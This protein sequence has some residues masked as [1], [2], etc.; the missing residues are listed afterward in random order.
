MD[1]EKKYGKI[2]LFTSS[3]CEECEKFKPEWIK[4]LKEFN[5]HYQHLF[6][7]NFIQHTIYNPL[8]KDAVKQREKILQY[9]EKGKD[10]Y[11][12][13]LFYLGGADASSTS[14]Y[15]PEKK[16]GKKDYERNDERNNR[17]GSEKWFDDDNGERETKEYKHTFTPS[18]S[19][20]SQLSTSSQK[21]GLGHENLA[22][23]A[24][25]RWKPYWFS[26]RIFRTFKSLMFSFFIVYQI[27]PAIKSVPFPIRQEILSHSSF[28]SAKKKLSSK[29]TSSQLSS[30]KLSSRSSSPRPSSPGGYGGRQVP[31]C[32]ENNDEL[33][34]RKEVMDGIYYITNWPSIK[35]DLQDDFDQLHKEEEREHK[36]YPNIDRILALH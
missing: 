25:F 34:N 30:R 1:D 12:L 19:S 17:N 14:P 28:A 15:P 24:P 20:S 13:L 16:D 23:A 22:S 6:P 33:L 36:N 21:G 29:K 18:Q 2:M 26:S 10:G 3:K 9:A 31:I 5:K 4:F 32:D 11:P 35:K 27:S 7:P 8:A